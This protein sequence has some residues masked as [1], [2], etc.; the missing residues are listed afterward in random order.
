MIIDKYLLNM[1]FQIKTYKNILGLFIA[2]NTF[3]YDDENNNKGMFLERKKVRRILKG[4]DFTERYSL[5]RK[6]IIKKHPWD[7]LH[8]LLSYKKIKSVNICFVNELNI[9]NRESII[10]NAINDLIFIQEKENRQFLKQFRKEAIK[11]FTFI[12]KI[13]LN[14]T[15]I[16]FILN[17]MDAYW[18]GYSFVIDKIGYVIAGPGVEKNQYETIRHELLHMVVPM[19]K[20]SK[21]IISINISEKLTQLGYGKK[22]VLRDEYIV[23]ALNMLYEGQV[24][25]QDIIKKIKEKEKIFPDIGK[26]VKFFRG[27]LKKATPE[28]GYRVFPLNPTC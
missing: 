12:K 11:L 17:P 15:K 21:E 16:I 14:I 6:L 25:K 19:F 18:R 3:G 22:S 1:N 13:P 5:L 9:F 28:N 10:S 20:I 4:H 24:L 27:E 26:L 7:L 2:L 8:I 23:I